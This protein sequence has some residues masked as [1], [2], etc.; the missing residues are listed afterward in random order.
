MSKERMARYHV[1]LYVKDADLIRTTFGESI[2]FNKA[3]RDMVRQYL[4]QMSKHAEERIVSKTTEIAK[5]LEL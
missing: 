2:G 5:G 1:R 3:V 4:L